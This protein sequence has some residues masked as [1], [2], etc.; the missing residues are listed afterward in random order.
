[1]ADYNVKHRDNERAN[2]NPQ[3]NHVAEDCWNRAIKFLCAASERAIKIID[4]IAVTKKTINFFIETSNADPDPNNDQY[5]WCNCWMPVDIIDP[6][7]GSPISKNSTIRWWAGRP[8]MRGGRGA[9]LALMHEIG[10]EYQ[11]QKP[12]QYIHFMTLFDY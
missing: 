4:D 12:E 9:E 2:V 1:M 10:H 3:K 8:K 5:G 7:N 11:W 6:A